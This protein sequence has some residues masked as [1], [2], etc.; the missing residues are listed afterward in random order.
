M[1]ESR[2]LGNFGF[3]VS[4]ELGS[5]KN[6]WKTLKYVDLRA[7]RVKVSHLEACHFWC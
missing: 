6:R 1:P 2:H 4:R 7:L 3:R 5:N